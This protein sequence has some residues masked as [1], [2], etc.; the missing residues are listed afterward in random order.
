MLRTGS[1]YLST[2]TRSAKPHTHSTPQSR[3]HNPVLQPV[4]LLL[5]IVYVHPADAKIV[6]I[7]PQLHDITPSACTILT[8]VALIN[9]FVTSSRPILRNERQPSVRNHVI[10]RARSTSSH[11]GTKS[12]ICRLC[13]ERRTHSTHGVLSRHCAN[14]V[15]NV[16]TLMYEH[17]KLQELDTGIKLFICDT[18]G[19]TGLHT[20]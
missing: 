11:F 1:D 18:N 10:V 15:V 9:S 13:P 6:Y 14:N 2:P 7:E 16:R 4:P 20:I 19:A 17:L 12:R 3:L 5:T 8:A